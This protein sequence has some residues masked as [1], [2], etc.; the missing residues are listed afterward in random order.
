MTALPELRLGFVAIARTTFDIQLAQEVTARARAL[1]AGSELAL[2]GPETLVTT[3]DEAHSAAAHLADQPLDA[4]VILQATFADSTLAL[5]L[6]E[7][8]DA[9]PVLWAVPEAFT[10]ERLRLNAL[11]G[12]NL[13]AHALMRA[14]RP[15][16]Y[17][18]AAPDDPAAAAK[19]RTVARAG[20]VRRRLRDA[21]IGRVGAHPEGFDT[22]HY[23]APGLRR[24]LGVQVEPLEL[25]AVF[26]SARA[27]D[28]LMVD[29]VAAGL[30]ARAA[31]LDD[32]EPGP[33][34]G[35]LA[36]YTALRDLAD[37]MQL[38]GLAVRCWPEFFTD[39]G[40]AACGALS[41]LSNDHTPGACEADV[42]GAITQVLLQWI[43]GEP[44]FGSD[45][46]A[47]DPDYDGLVLWHCGQ[48]PLA[49]ADPDAQ[50]GVTIHSNRRLP[51]L[52]EFALKPGR[53]TL[54][55]LSVGPAGY[56]LVVGAGEIVR[57][58]RRFSGTTGVLRC[59]RPAAAVLDTIL[60]EGLE[61]HLTLTYGDHVPVL[62]SLAK[63]LQLPVL[64]L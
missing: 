8:L 19:I 41:L 23:D 31:G 37:Q 29:A 42:H 6:V 30:R 32:L 28:P 46:V 15:Y 14:S 7:N 25:A 35:T 4:L 12:I 49:M 13:A 5:A 50:L 54:A 11:C 3:L 2:A 51:L 52:F 64:R 48:A 59:E 24:L 33:T 63:M 16:D 56:R 58:P 34:R 38:D 21:R 1:L 22:C 39:L 61:H 27:A 20:Q 40:C 57:A 17:L 9:P 45:V 62:L 26:A 18:L 10:G 36:V 47:L 53:V 60:M 43:S 44:A 55:R